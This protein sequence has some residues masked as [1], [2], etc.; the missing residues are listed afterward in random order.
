MCTSNDHDQ[1]EHLYKVAS[2]TSVAKLRF[3]FL[4]LEMLVGWMKRWNFG[5]VVTLFGTDSA[6]V[7][8]RMWHPHK[9]KNVP[10]K[11]KLDPRRFS[12][13]KS[14][15]VEELHPKIFPP[16]LVINPLKKLNS[17]DYL[18]WSISILYTP[19]PRNISS[20]QNDKV[21]QDA[22]G[23]DS[24]EITPSTLDLSPRKPRVFSDHHSTVSLVC[25]VWKELPF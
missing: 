3:L 25:F 7:T 18:V 17:K 21:D 14:L 23:V 2:L 16:F 19:H 24:M 11:K 15:W 20:K 8:N 9:K 4:M 10:N 12:L 1:E 5:H 6:N 13:F 22:F